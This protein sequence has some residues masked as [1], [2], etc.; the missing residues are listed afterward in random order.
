MKS[1]VITANGKEELHYKELAKDQAKDLQSAGRSIEAIVSGE[2]T[3]AVFSLLD[4]SIV[5]VIHVNQSPS[6][7]IESAILRNHFRA[8][9]NLRREGYSQDDI[10]GFV[11]LSETEL[12]DQQVPPCV[13]S[14]G[15]VGCEYFF[16][17]GRKQK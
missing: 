9:R 1:Y 15:V 4:P 12:A 11:R 3:N 16:K 2:G 8:Y 10:E 13:E 7:E 5:A 17:V 6:A 14:K